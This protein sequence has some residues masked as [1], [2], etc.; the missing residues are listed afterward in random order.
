MALLPIRLRFYDVKECGYFPPRVRGKS[1]PVSPAFGDLAD[2]LN[3][4]AEWANKPG[5]RL[6]DTRTF[7]KP[8]D[9][10]SVFCFSL[11]RGMSGAR[12]LVT[13]NEVPSTDQGVSSVMPDAP[14]GNSEIHTSKHPK[15]SIPGYPTYFLI[16]PD[17]NLLATVV[18]KGHGRTIGKTAM[19]YYVRQYMERYSRHVIFEAEGEGTTGKSDYTIA[20]Y[21]LNGEGPPQELVPRFRS[22]VHRQQSELERLRADRERIR[23]VISRNFLVENDQSDKAIWQGMLRRLG[24]R[25]SQYNTECRYD[26][27]VD[28]TPTADDLEGIIN[29]WTESSEADDGADVGFVMDGESSKVYWLRNALATSEATLSVA[30]DNGGHMDPRSLLTELERGLDVHLSNLT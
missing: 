16:L 14:V 13:W 28:A 8:G 21:A 24:F 30:I 22:V 6:G 1:A 10:S 11:I 26:Y 7:G 18:R 12:L 5:M 3:D 4:I 29:R 17:A 9:G 20:G 19:E 2:A 27:K 25:Q 15:G 23:R